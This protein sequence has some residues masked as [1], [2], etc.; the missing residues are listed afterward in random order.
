MLNQNYKTKYGEDA[1]QRQKL[2][3]CAADLAALLDAQTQGEEYVALCPAHADSKPSFVFRDSAET[4]KLIMHCHA[5]CEYADIVQALAEQGITLPRSTRSS[6]RFVTH[7]SYVDEQGKELYRVLRTLK[8]DFP[9]GRWINGQFVGGLGDTQPVLYNLDKIAAAPV[10]VP[11]FATEGE[12]DADTAAELGLLATTNYGGADPKKWRESYTAYLKDRQVILVE[13]NDPKGQLRVAELSKRLA[14]YV[15]SVEIITFRDMEKGADLTDWVDARK[16][17]G[18]SKAD[19]CQLLNAKREALKPSRT[20]TITAKLNG[21]SI[22]EFICQSGADQVTWLLRGTLPLGEAFALIGDPGIGKSTTALIL[23]R[24]AQKTRVKNGLPA[25]KILYLALEGNLRNIADAVVQAELNLEDVVILRDENGSCKFNMTDRRDCKAVA[26]QIVQY[27][28]STEGVALVIYDSF[29]AG[30]QDLSINR[31]EAVIPMQ[32]LNAELDA[33]GITICY[34]NHS[35]KGS[36]GDGRAVN[37]AIGSSLFLGQVRTALFMKEDPQVPQSRRLAVI[38]SN[39][40]AAPDPERDYYS[41]KAV[42][43]FRFVAVDEVDKLRAVPEEDDKSDT[44]K[45]VRA[46]ARTIII[47][48]FLRSGVEEVLSTE[49][50]TEAGK[51]GVSEKIIKEVMIEIGIQAKKVGDRW[52]RYWPLRKLYIPENEKQGAEQKEVPSTTPAETMKPA[53]E[54]LDQIPEVIVPSVGYLSPFVEVDAK[55]LA[56]AVTGFYISHHEA[57]DGSL[58]VRLKIGPYFRFVRLAGDVAQCFKRACK[59]KVLFSGKRMAVQV[60]DAAARGL[61]ENGTASV[62]TFN[63][64]VEISD[65]WPKVK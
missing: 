61:L 58:L 12:K 55:S 23:G 11:V 17:E 38:K 18:K 59:L 49:I 42:G 13:D 7:Y 46:K 63:A 15:K 25:G 51:R 52:V 62:A 50:H 65:M 20:G 47:E 27:E 53:V 14:P 34:I 5:G 31:P 22:A 9:I 36:T 28:E 3:T 60:D 54:I 32:I 39:R 24:E 1:F 64:P 10:D 48:M 19:I 16:A 26:D 56:L 8:K 21:M 35:P 41:I 43:G 29:S 30:S 40:Y 2:V 6:G 45:T 44:T 33:R 4:G 57:E 37:A